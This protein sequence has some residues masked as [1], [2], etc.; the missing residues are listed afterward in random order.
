MPLP[1]LIGYKIDISTEIC[2]QWRVHPV[3]CAQV[4]RSE[5]PTQADGK[6]V[7]LRAYARKR[8]DHE[9]TAGTGSA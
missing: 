4:A 9:L 7:D 5:I 3:P 8:I 1:L 6:I 2:A